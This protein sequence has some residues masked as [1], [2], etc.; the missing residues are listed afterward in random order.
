MENP[1][2]NRS[3][4]LRLRAE[5]G[6]IPRD[7]RDR[8]HRSASTLK[9]VLRVLGSS[10]RTKNRL[11]KLPFRPPRNFADQ[12]VFFITVFKPETSGRRGNPA[13]ASLS[14][15]TDN[16]SSWRRTISFLSGFNA[17]NPFALLPIPSRLP[18]PYSL[19]L[20]LRAPYPRLGFGQ[21]ARD[22][23]W[24]LLPASSWKR[25]VVT[26]SWGTKVERYSSP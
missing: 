15:S 21:G 3:R 22:S 19:P 25:M 7:T 18:S 26:R 24:P 1:V 12:S 20:P 17:L 5:S 14:A 23:A 16:H 11:L 9:G 13:P 2:Q 4:L 6:R 10:L 8:R